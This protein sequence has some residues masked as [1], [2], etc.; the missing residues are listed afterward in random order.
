MA[1]RKV[2]LPGEAGKAQLE[3]GFALLGEAVNCLS[4][5]DEWETIQQSDVLIQKAKDDLCRQLAHLETVASPDYLM[6]LEETINFYSGSVSDAAI[7][8]GFRVA[9]KLFHAIS[10][11][12]EMSQ[13]IA[14]RSR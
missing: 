8:Y 10:R 11:P 6:K 5:S 12:T 2:C 14:K 7:L 3:Q 1:E 13:Y 4:R 9:L